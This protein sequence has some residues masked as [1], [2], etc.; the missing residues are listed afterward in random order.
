MDRLPP[1]IRAAAA[2]GWRL[3]PI[4]ARDKLPLLKAWPQLATSDLSQL[5]AWAA[6]HPACNWG[7]AT[8]PG[9]GVFVLDVD[10]EPGIAALLAYR[11]QGLELP[12]TLSVI[13]G[14]GTHIY[15]RWTEGLSIRNSAGK[16]AKGLDIRGEG[17]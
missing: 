4:R 15:F 9:S 6:Q 11:E 13:T 10:A 3:L 14:R 16:L 2:R 1:E 17:G 8:G 7:V 12:N 5:E